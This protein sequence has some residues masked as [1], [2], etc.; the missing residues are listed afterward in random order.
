MVGRA[1]VLAS[2]GHTRGSRPADFRFPETKREG[3]KA[4]RLV[5]L[6]LLLTKKYIYGAEPRAEK[7]HEMAVLLYVAG[8]EA[9]ISP[10]S[11]FI[12]CPRKH[13]EGEKERKEKRRRKK[14]NNG[15]LVLCRFLFS[16]DSGS[17]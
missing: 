15:S 7:S 8:V 13:T 11:S 14:G 9:K 5:L 1:L 17:Y 12:F 3:T 4:A 10:T 2:G 6:K 16:G